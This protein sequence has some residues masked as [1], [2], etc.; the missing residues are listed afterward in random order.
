MYS[1]IEKMFTIAYSYWRNTLTKDIYSSNN[2][3]AMQQRK[4]PFKM[5]TADFLQYSQTE[6]MNLLVQT[7]YITGSGLAKQVLLTHFSR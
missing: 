4:T 6:D 2:Y 1:F 7:D 3:V 5:E